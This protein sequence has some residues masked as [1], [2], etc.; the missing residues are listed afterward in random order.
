MI[1]GNCGCTFSLSSFF[2]HIMFSK[3]KQAERPVHQQ[4]E[5]YKLEKRA[6]QP[7]GYTVK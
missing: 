1:T 2:D 4:L 5:I 6:L 7:A 3:R